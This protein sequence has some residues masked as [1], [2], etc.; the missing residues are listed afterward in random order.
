MDVSV[1]PSSQDMLKNHDKKLIVMCPTCARNDA[2]KKGQDFG[3][4]RP[5]TPEQAQ[6]LLANQLFGIGKPPTEQNE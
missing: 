6:E 5:L 1:S 4:F 3:D 2:M